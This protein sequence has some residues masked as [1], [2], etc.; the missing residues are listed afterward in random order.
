MKY[1]NHGGRFTGDPAYFYHV[2]QALRSLL[3][4]YAF[5]PSDFSH[6]IFHMPNGKFPLKIANLFQFTRQQLQHGFTVLEI[7]NPYAAN[8]LFGLT[9]VL[10]QAKPN[11]LV[12]MVTYGSGSGADALVLRTT[13]MIT[14]RHPCGVET[15]LRQRLRISV[16]D[17]QRLQ[18]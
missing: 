5:K 1:P 8:V 16:T 3:D 10:D 2:E 15:L 4:T 11:Q 13:S 17:Y 18:I 7:G 9:A 12:L 14:K 6:V